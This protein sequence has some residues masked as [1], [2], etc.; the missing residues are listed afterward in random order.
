MD[1]WYRQR[2]RELLDAT[3]DWSFEGVSSKV[4]HW[5]FRLITKI[6]LIRHLFKNQAVDCK[7][8][9]KSDN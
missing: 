3:G 4:K 6:L 1:R 8:I 5:P 9:Y 7:T 2:R